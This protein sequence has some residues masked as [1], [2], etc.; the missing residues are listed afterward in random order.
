MGIPWKKS[1]GKRRLWW[2]ASASLAARSI[3]AL[4]LLGILPAQAQEASFEGQPV[5]QIRIIDDKG[6]PF[7][8]ATPRLELEAGKPFDLANE[9]Q[10]LRDLYRWGDF[11]D[12]RVAVTPLTAGLRVDFI[13]R[14][15]Y[16]VNVVL[17]EGLKEP[18]TAPAALASLRLNLG[19]PF[20]ES[21]LGAARD[22][23]LDTLRDR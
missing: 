14:R 9:R 23:L 6:E 22:R 18:P 2:W 3:F 20:R 7:P 11:S 12:I 1:I 17:I 13:V 21:S 19:E 10:S 5:A 4:F 15:N 16:Y 8:G